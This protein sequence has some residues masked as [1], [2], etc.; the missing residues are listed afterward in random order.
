MKYFLLL[1]AFTFPS[2]ALAQK[3][4][5]VDSVQVNTQKAPQKEE[6]PGQDDFIDITEE[7]HPLKNIQALIV[8]PEQARK[9][10]LEG[11]V[12]V[13]MLIG[14]DGEIKKIEILHADYDIFRQPVLDALKKVKY[15]PALQGKKPVAI[16]YTQ[17]VNFILNPLDREFRRKK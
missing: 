7:P 4:S 13:Q 2:L 11:K 5:S 14:K 17:S 16:W 15:T 6:E 3:P 10:A 9:S 1:A 8:Y 12:T